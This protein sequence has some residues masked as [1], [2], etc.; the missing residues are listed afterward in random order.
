MALFSFAERLSGHHWSWLATVLIG[1]GHVAWITLEFIYIPDPSWL[2]PV[3]LG[4]G[5]A[6][7]IL[8]MSSSVRHH[9]AIS[10]ARAGV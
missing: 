7:L 6:L 1:A 3:Y 8:P 10:S 4:V 2:E 5:L 9:L